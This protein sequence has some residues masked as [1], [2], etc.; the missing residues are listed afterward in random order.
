MYVGFLTKLFCHICFLLIKTNV[1][2]IIIGVILL[3]ECIVKQFS[4]PILIL[5][6]LKVILWAGQNTESVQQKRVS[7]FYAFSFPCPPFSLSLNT[8]TKKGKKIYT[9]TQNQHFPKAK[10]WNSRLSK[11]NCLIGFVIYKSAQVPYSSLANR[12]SNNSSFYCLY[13]L[14]LPS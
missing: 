1:R 4:V 14:K 11:I 9:Q 8:H 3:L 13:H 7:S 6:N 10:E 5:V 12:Q 2:R